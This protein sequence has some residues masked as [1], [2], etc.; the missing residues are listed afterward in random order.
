MP[1]FSN[2]TIS[3]KYFI[4]DLYFR[5]LSQSE[6]EPE[7]ESNSERLR[8][9]NPLRIASLWVVVTPVKQIRQRP[10]G[11]GF[12]PLEDL[13]I[14]NPS[15]PESIVPAWIILFVIV[16][17]PSWAI[18]LRRLGIVTLFL[19]LLWMPAYG[20]ANDTSIVVEESDTNILRSSSIAVF[21][22]QVIVTVC[23]FL[24]MT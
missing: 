10:I 12:L 4:E 11:F 1:S 3:N 6:S 20:R 7:Y 13:G 21:G 18:E 16:R 22:Q 17:L 8:L 14:H 15:P 24:R 9:L 19:S 23:S 5:W 2:Y